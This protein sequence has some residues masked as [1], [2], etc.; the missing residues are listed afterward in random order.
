MTW[1]TEEEVTIEVT[2][3]DEAGKISFSA[4]APHP[5]VALTAKLSDSDGV[6]VTSMRWEWSRSRSERGSYVAIDG[7]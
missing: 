1:W 5:G 7:R 4:L 2:N 3:V 6:V